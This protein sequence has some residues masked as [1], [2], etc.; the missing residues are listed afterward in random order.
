[1]DGVALGFEELMGPKDVTD[2]VIDAD[3]FALA[4]TFGW[5]FVFGGGA[6]YCSFAKCEDGPGVSFA[7]VMEL[8]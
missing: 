3:Y 5:D 6:G 4:R 1:M 2:F 8:V 7:V